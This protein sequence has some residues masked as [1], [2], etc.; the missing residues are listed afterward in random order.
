M[1]IA[2]I[3]GGLVY[4]AHVPRCGGTSVEQYLTDRFGPLAFRDL[5]FGAVARRWSRSSP[6]HIAVE[7]LD[8]LIP[9]EF[10]EARF[11]VIR[12]PAARL[13]SVFLFQ[14]DIEG[15]IDRAASFAG[16]LERSLTR[17]RRAPWQYD[18]HVRP[19]VAIV[20]EGATI[21]RLEEG[22]DKLVGWLDA[23]TGATAPDLVLQRKN[24]YASRVAWAGVEA[25][26]APEMSARA[27][28]LIA[29]HYAQDFE[30][31]GYDPDPK[32]WSKGDLT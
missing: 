32:T 29:S 9:A 7:D 13:Q 4:F 15:R 12:H 6:Q 5:H 22:L 31:F 28:E 20:P 2:R 8:R 23:L 26:P 17:A 21:F 19:M 18:N 3:A 30:R 11:A 24:G 27:A 14:R 25:G 16:W 1:P 10:F